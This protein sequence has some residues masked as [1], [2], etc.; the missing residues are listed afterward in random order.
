MLAPNTSWENLPGV[1]TNAMRLSPDFPRPRSSIPISR[2]RTWAGGFVLLLS[3]DTKRQFRPCAW[4]SASRPAIPP[5]ITLLLRPWIGP[6]TRQ[7]QKRNLPFTGASI[8]RRRL[9][10][11]LRGQNSLSLFDS[12]AN[13]KPEGLLGA[14]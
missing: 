8:L 5:S 2:K 6:V 3:K 12:G 13:R 9:R 7:K 14:D 4:R 1:T 11:L 10:Q